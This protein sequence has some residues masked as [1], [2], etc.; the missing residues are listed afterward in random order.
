[1]I[2]PYKTHKKNAMLD[3]LELLMLKP[4]SYSWPSV[5]TFHLHPAKQ[6][7]LCWLE[8][9]SSQEIHDKSV[10]FFKHSDLKLSQTKTSSEDLSEFE[11]A[12]FILPALIK[13]LSWSPHHWIFTLWLADWLHSGHLTWIILIQSSFGYHFSWSRWSCYFNRISTW[14]SGPAICS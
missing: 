12:I 11:L 13:R 3:N 1:M 5:R 9:T 7:E 10:M 4:S 6:I 8:S 14:H 2:K